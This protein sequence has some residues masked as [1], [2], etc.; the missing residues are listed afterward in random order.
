MERQLL[1]ARASCAIAIVVFA[2]PLRAQ[3]TMGT[4]ATIVIPVIAQTPSFGSEVTAYNPSGAALTVTVSFYDA[5]NTS[6]PGLKACT[7]LSLP[8]GRSVQFSVAGQ[9]ALPAGSNFGLLILAEQSGTQ[10]F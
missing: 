10:R 3:T 4:S 6:S 9:C 8:A 5:Q 7:P 2:L 1:W